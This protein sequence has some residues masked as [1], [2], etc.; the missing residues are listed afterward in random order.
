MTL[1]RL[2]EQEALQRLEAWR[3]PNGPKC[4]HCPAQGYATHGSRFGQLKCADCGQRFRVTAGTPL[5]GTHL[6][7]KV[8]LDV[9]Q[10]EHKALNGEPHYGVAFLAR[11]LNQ[12]IM[13]LHK[14]VT[15]C[16]VLLQDKDWRAFAAT[17]EDPVP[18]PIEFPC[19]FGTIAVGGR[20]LQDPSK[21]ADYIHLW[22]A[23]RALPPEVRNAHEMT[24]PQRRKLTKGVTDKRIVNAIHK[25]RAEWWQ[26]VRAARRYEPDRAKADAE[27]EQR[28]EWAEEQ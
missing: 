20:Q 22:R 13:T 18:E 1:A 12:R 6:P 8:W 4:P 3:W 21:P 5:E 16:R 2:F 25:A 7:L 19:R 14:V 9:L 23:V 10:Y 15:Q 24:L 26:C 27:K 28:R 11:V 17:L